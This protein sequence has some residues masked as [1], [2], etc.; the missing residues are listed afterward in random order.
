MSRKINV[1]SL[2]E[3]IDFYISIINRFFNTLNGRNEEQLYANILSKRVNQLWNH[4]GI[5]Y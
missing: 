1:P 2:N 3:C 5:L 4:S